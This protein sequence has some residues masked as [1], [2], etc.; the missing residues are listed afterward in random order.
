MFHAQQANAIAL[1]MADESVKVSQHSAELMQAII[2]QVEKNA[3]I[4]E[5]IYAA[6]QEQSTGAQHINT[7]LQLLNTVT[8]HN[9]QSSQEMSKDADML[10]R[11]ASKIKELIE[12]FKL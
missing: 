1:S 4:V 8:Q 10:N 12:F 6:S 2:P 7:A 3:Q 5:E 9:A 11:N